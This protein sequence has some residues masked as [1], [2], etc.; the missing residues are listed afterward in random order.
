M[1]HLPEA[2]FDPEF[3]E[4]HETEIRS[5]FKAQLVS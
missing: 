3:F 4:R 1:D 2:N 5:A